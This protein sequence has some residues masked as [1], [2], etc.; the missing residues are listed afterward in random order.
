M[1]ISVGCCTLGQFK[2]YLGAILWQSTLNGSAF[3]YSNLDPFAVYRH[4]GFLRGAG[5]SIDA[6]LSV[7]A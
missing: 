5:I 2:V 4:R 7:D 3:F 6:S 1:D